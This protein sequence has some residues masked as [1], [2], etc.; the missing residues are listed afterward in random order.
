MTQEISSLMDGELESHASEQAIRTCA[1]EEGA[2]TWHDYHLI[3]DALRHGAAR[4]S[5]VAERVKAALAAEP[6]VL[7]P[8]SRVERVTRVALAAAA[9]VATVAVVGWIGFTGTSTAPT[10]PTLVKTEPTGPALTTVAITAPAS[11]S[12]S[13]TS[14][15]PAPAPAS[16]DVQ[17]YLAAHRQTASSEFYRPVASTARQP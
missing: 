16:V 15:A 3:S 7:A 11:T 6:T 8:R 10:T 9:S 13:A 1:T 5:R 2:R 17:H 12:T 4:P 14:A